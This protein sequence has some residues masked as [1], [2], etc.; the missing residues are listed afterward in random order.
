MAVGVV[1]VGAQERFGQRVRTGRGGP[2]SRSSRLVDAL[3]A[4]IIRSIRRRVGMSRVKQVVV[5]VS[6]AT[7]RIVIVPASP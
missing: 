7:F 4:G 5:G 6:D 3:R 2:S 1:G